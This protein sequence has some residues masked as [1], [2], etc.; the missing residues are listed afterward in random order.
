MGHTVRKTAEGLA[1]ALADV[2]NGMSY[3]QAA[4]KHRLDRHALARYYTGE[5]AAAEDVAGPKKSG[6]PPISW[7]P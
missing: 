7:P 2:D 3:T 4:R 6:R 1:E 5:M